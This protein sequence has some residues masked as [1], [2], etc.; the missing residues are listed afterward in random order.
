[1]TKMAILIED[2]KV[3]AM[4]FNLILLYTKG[5]NNKSMILLVLA[6]DCMPVLCGFSNRFQICYSDHE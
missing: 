5:K 1:M 6:S 2:S 3:L 4:D